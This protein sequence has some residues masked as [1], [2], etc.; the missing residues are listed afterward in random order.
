M[1]PSQ[2]HEHQKKIMRGIYENRM[3]LTSFRDKPKGWKL[4]SGVWSPFYIQLRNLSSFPEVL[5]EVGLAMTKL[6]KE[7][8]PDVT[9]LVGVAFSGIP[10][11]TAIS[12]ESGIPSCHTRKIHGVHSSQNLREELGKYGQHSLLEGVLEED[13][14]ICLVDDLVT[15]MKSTLQA[16]S[17]VIE[18]IRRRN[19]NNIVCDDIAVI[20]DRQQGAMKKAEGMKIRLHSLI[21]F[22]DEGLPLIQDIMND[23]EYRLITNYLSDKHKDQV[24]LENAISV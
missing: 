21:N 20:I 16:R 22:V 14:T 5:S 6:I 11:A 10:I 18:E 12:L 24:P 7:S 2:L 9:K 8:A 23:E 3:L 15:S 4:F 17:Q 13:D 1:N 19:L